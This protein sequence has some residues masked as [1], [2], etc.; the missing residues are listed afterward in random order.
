MNLLRSILTD[1]LHLF[2]PHNCRGCGTDI[3]QQPNLLCLKCINQLPYT[4]EAN[5][6]A[7]H[8]ENIFV[9]RLPVQAACCEFFFSKDSLIQRLIHQL[10]Y[11]GDTEIGFYMGELMGKD[12]LA[13]GRFSNLDL[14]MPLPLHPN[15]ERKRGYNQA[16]IICNGIS[17]VMNVP[18]ST[19]NLVR[20]RFTE[21]QTRKHRV[22]RWENVDGS[23]MINNESVLRGKHILL[24]DDVITTGATLESCGQC[25]INIPAAKLSIAALAYA[26]K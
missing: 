20:R 16:A 8:T 25:I 4:S 6:A 7:N 14:L 5:H 9:G 2:Y 10:K 11:K 21:T 19:G 1:T 15:K 23:F 18:V 3:L 12:L 26:S 13:G 17:S 24:V 22:D